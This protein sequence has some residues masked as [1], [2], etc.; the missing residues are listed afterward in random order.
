MRQHFL[1]IILVLVSLIAW[2]QNKKKYTVNSK[3]AIALYDSALKA[4]NQTDLYTTKRLLEESLSIE[5]NFIEA[6]L[7]LSQVYMEMGEANKSIEYILKAQSIDKDFHPRAFFTL[8]LLYFSIGEYQ[9]ALSSYETFLSYRDKSANMN[10]LASKNIERCRFALDQIAHPVPFAPIIIGKNVNTDLDEYWPSLSADERQLVYTVRLP[11]NPDKGIKG[12]KWQED[13]YISYCNENSNW[14]KGTPVPPPINTEFNEGAQS[15]SADGKTIYFTVCRGVCNIY[16]SVLEPDGSW[17]IPQKLPPTIN[18]EKYSEK[19][20]SIS[21][22]GR[23]L[24]FVSNRPGGLGKFDIWKSEKQPDG[25]WGNAVN[26]GNVINTVE[27]EQSPFIHFDNQTLY[28]SSAGHM[29]MGDQDIFVSRRDSTGNWL[30]PVNLGYPINTHQSEEGLIVNAKGNTAYYSSDINPEYGRDILTFELYPKVRPT[31]TSFVT[32]IARNKKTLEPIRTS[33][34]LVELKNQNERMVIETSND[35]TFLVC[36]PTDKRY[37]LFASAPGFL[38]YSEHFDLTGYHSVDK[39]FRRDILLQ[40]IEKGEVIILQNVFFAFNSHALL[41]ESTVELNKLLDVLNQN[42]NVK[43]EISGHTDDVG[44]DDYNLKLSERRAKA[45]ADYLISKGV[46]P[47][48]LKWIGY[49]KTKP[50]APN[51]SAKERAQNRRTEVRIL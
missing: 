20:P 14:D 38:F 4:Y 44:D 15:V 6:H 18:T 49:G 9:K 46:N 5:P 21:P 17:S 27:S 31:P 32:G 7:V 16:Q 34:K 12:L 40:P 45:V 8:G 41:P 48:R 3:R 42:P 36:L 30:T 11:K 26:L 29:G 43:I 47:D 35:G 51:T 13:L 19:Q 22:D 25:T 33:I 50:I 10:N 39:P 1:I 28:F 37:G 24:Y 2:G 23:T